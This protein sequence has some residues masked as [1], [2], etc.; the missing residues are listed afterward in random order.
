MLMAELES[1]GS[2]SASDSEL[3]KR[4]GWTRERATQ[5][6]GDLERAG[7]VASR[8]Q[9]ATHT[10]GCVPTRYALDSSSTTLLR[11]QS[12]ERLM[13]VARARTPAC[14]QAIVER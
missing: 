6:L 7:L 1:M 5:V 13:A 10:P 14:G 4:L 9:R 12:D 8:E 11:T 2:A 3:P